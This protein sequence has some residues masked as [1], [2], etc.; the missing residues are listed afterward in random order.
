MWLSSCSIR[1]STR[2]AVVLLS[3]KRGPPAR[4]PVVCAM[5]LVGCSSE[6]R[7]LVFNK[8]YDLTK[9]NNNQLWQ[10]DIPINL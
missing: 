7:R 2:L 5:D 9:G 4:R 8:T 6:Q 1:L 3:T 10:K